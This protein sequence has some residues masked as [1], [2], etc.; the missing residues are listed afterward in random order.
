M[1]FRYIYLCKQFVIA[2]CI[3]DKLKRRGEKKSK[4]LQRN[5]ILRGLSFE[6]QMDCLRAFTLGAL[7]ERA[8]WLCPLNRPVLF[9]PLALHTERQ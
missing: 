6:T 7:A 9:P 8:G 2:W 5:C 4:W 1:R 3:A